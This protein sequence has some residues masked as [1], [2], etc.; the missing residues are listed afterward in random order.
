M[1][2]RRKS[3]LY[4]GLRQLRNRMVIA[5]KRLKFVHP[6]ASVHHSSRISKDFVAA[7]YVFVGR[8]CTVGPHVSIG[9]Y[10]MLASNIAVVGD[11][12]EWK[13]VGVPMQF[14][15][16]PLQSATR[17]GADVWVGHGVIV[18][19][20]ASIGEGAI[21]AAGSV[22][23]KDVAP[24]AIVAGVPAQ[25]IGERFPDAESRQS[26]QAMLRGPLIEPS[27]AEPAEFYDLAASANED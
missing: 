14:A 19:R 6:S 13:V 23:V 25:R 11:D 15:G 3:G 8:D 22:V 4:R 27:F 16:R 2:M 24:Y 7:E 5:R 18:M 17:I 1:I 21:V 26:H 9:R 12:H 10:S 20:G